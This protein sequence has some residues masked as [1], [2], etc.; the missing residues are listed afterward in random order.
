MNFLSENLSIFIPFLDGRF[1][2]LLIAL[3]L[4]QYLKYKKLINTNT[5][6][7]KLMGTLNIIDGHIL[8]PYL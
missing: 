2:G 3:V 4:L 5:F 8:N 1:L 6:D 7:I